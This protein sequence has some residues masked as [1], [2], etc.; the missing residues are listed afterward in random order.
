MERLAMT[1]MATEEPLFPHDKRRK[2][3]APKDPEVGKELQRLMF[4]VY[5][6][7]FREKYGV[8]PNIQ[9]KDW[10]ILKSLLLGALAE[11]STVVEKGAEVERHLRQFFA[12]DG[13]QFVKAAGY[14]LV[15]FRSQWNKLTHLSYV[16]HASSGV[17]H[18]QHIPRCHDHAEHSRKTLAALRANHG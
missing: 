17:P 18:C 5:G 11:P 15:I 2:P 3:K 13:D 12:W 8:M 16:Q 4:R 1:V 10:G 14:N 7:L 9:P 6:P